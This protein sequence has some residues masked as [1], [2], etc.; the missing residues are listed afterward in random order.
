MFS[1]LWQSIMRE[2]RRLTSRWVYLMG[3]I[4]VPIGCT[5]LF[6]S[7]MDSGLPRKVP[8]AVV[9]LDH[10]SMSRQITRSLNAMEL[11]DIQGAYENYDEALAAV[12][13][14]DIY[15]FFII[16][17]NF[18]KNTLSGRT[19]TLE[20]FTNMTYYV[21]GT[22]SYK[23]FKTIAVTTAGAVV[24]TTLVS[25]GAP[26]GE[27]GALLQPLVVD[28]HLTGN[29]WMNYNY[30]LTPTFM[31]C[32]IG[33]MV[34]LMTVFSITIE[35]KNAT[36]PQWLAT[37]RGNIWIALAGKLLPQAVI[38]FIVG[39]LIESIL[40]GW[41]HFPLNGSLAAMIVA[42]ALFVVASQAFATFVC[43]WLPNPRLALSVVSLLGILTFSIA[44][45]SFPVTS[46]YGAVAA[47]AYILP[48]RY[49]ILIYF[50]QALDG[51]PLYYA[52]MWFVALLLFWIIGFIPAM[53]L[54][55]A[56]L[57]PVYIP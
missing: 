37:A 26:S 8:T 6:L 9:D 22:L 2:L 41:N 43:A 32:L 25:T 28:Q 52:R 45:L 19:P 57:N 4:V 10:S 48:A 21:P 3:M 16:P 39:V 50:S 27:V 14:G 13:R 47:F 7:L 40:F 11:I 44:G 17:E 15:G 1:A 51:W 46:M 30:Y 54:R 24:K 36:G 5:L 53:R 29:P 33:L 56:M 35:I 12:R 38:F 49:M 23:G 18:Q 55:K 20:Y 31:I 34:M 42:M